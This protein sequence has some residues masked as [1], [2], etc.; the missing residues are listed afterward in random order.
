MTAAETMCRRHPAKP[1]DGVCDRCG[2]ELCGECQTALVSGVYCPSCRGSVR[3]QWIGTGLAVLFLA[4]LFFLPPA[5]LSDRL[6]GFLM[7]SVP[8]FYG[9]H[10]FRIAALK[11]RL[12]RD[13]CDGSAIH[14]LVL[15]LRASTA[16]REAIRRIDAYLASCEDFP[17]LKRAKAEALRSLGRPR[18]AARALSELIEADPF[19]KDYWLARGEAYED[20][21]DWLAASADYRQALALDPVHGE[22]AQRLAAVRTRLGRP[23]ASSLSAKGTVVI[24]YMPGAAVAPV[25]AKLEGKPARMD[26]D[27]TSGLVVLSR[28]L[29]ETIG[30]KPD[31]AG[32]ELWAATSGG[33]VKGKP[34]RVARLELQRLA[35]RDVEV[36]VDDTLESGGILGASFLSLFDVKNSPKRGKLVVQA[37]ASLV[38]E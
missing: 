16:Y 37:P 19:E 13:R 12:R 18:D 15:R 2:D 4:T 21:A 22:A 8:R 1:A 33:I 9:S 30:V 24:E 14:E 36:I 32:P 7:D 35:A 3:V 26:I 5:A 29:A 10:T 34:A 31:A 28:S 20:A 11:S 25:Q 17:A 27:A 23:E 38:S 6:P